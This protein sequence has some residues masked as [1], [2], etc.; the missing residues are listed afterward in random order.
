MRR[1]TRGERLEACQPLSTPSIRARLQ[2]AG[3][4]PAAPADRITLLRRA[5]RSTLPACSPPT[6]QESD[7]FLADK[8]ADA[9]EKT[10]DRLLSPRR[11]MG[12][13]G[14]V[15][16]WISRAM[17]R[18]KASK[19]TKRVPTPGAIGIYA[20]SKPSTKTSRTIALSKSRSPAMNFGRTIPGQGSPRPSIVTIRMR[21][22]RVNLQ[23]RRQEILN[24]ITDTVS[25]TFMAMTYGCARCH[26]HKF[27]P[28]LH[29][30]LPIVCR[31]SSPTP[32]PTITSP[33]LPPQ[34]ARIMRLEKAVW[35]EKTAPIRT[36]LAALARAIEGEN[37]KGP[38]RQISA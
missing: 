37:S 30:R 18:A 34:R 22:M 38:V 1:P 20:G 12:S 11:T 5:S 16:G 29:T 9:Y 24:D 36:Q 10:I 28:I 31:P 26:T 27:D 35:E 32:P 21:A 2:S 14:L 13:A 15:T 19:A 33:R 3:L 17:P 6:P 8:S 7:A 25:S 4:K 23:Q